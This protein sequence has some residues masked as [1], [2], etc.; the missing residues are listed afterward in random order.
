MVAQIISTGY[1]TRNPLHRIKV[2]RRSS[3]PKSS[4]SLGEAWSVECSR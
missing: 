4:M 3:S 1:S 2:K